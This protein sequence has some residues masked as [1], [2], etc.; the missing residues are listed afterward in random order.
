MAQTH[1]Q[2]DRLSTEH[3]E[4]HSHSSAKNSPSHAVELESDLSKLSVWLNHARGTLIGNCVGDAIGLS[5]EFMTRKEAKV[6]LVTRI[7]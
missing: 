5:T 1:R 4:H 6:I 2:D 3:L 7:A